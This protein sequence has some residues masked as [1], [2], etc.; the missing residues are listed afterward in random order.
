MLS[1]YTNSIHQLIQVF[2]KILKYA[3]ESKFHN[4]TLGRKFQISGHQ[5][6][7]GFSGHQVIGFF[8]ST[9]HTVT[10]F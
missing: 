7:I 6:T 5:V 4:V 8:N 1:L 10:G 2:K 3:K 9:F